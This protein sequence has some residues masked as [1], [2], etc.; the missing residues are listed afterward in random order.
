MAPPVVAVGADPNRRATALLMG[1]G[2]ADYL[3]LPEDV[4]LLHSS[5]AALLTRFQVGRTVR[6]GDGDIIPGAFEAIVARSPIMR[7]VLARA[8]RLLR[9]RDATALIIGETGTGKELLARAVHSG[10]PRREAPFV[11]VNCS[12]LPPQLVESE[13]FG[14]ERGAFTDAHAAN[15][16]LFEVAEGGTLFLDE[17]GALPVALQAKLL[18]VLENKEVRRVGGTRTRIADVRIIAATNTQLDRAV[19]DGT[20]RGDLFYRLS[21]LT[22][23]LP[24]LRERA[25][26]LEPLARHFLETFAREY[27]LPVPVLDAAAL[28]ALRT[29]D[30]P[31]NVRELKN[32]MERALLLAEPGH[33]A[34][35]ELPRTAAPR[36][37]AG[38]TLP[39][40]APLDAIEAAAARSMLAACEGNRSEAAR[41]LGISRRRLRRLLGLSDSEA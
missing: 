30:W 2:A 8:G 12:A 14:H 4:E 21:I 29:Y 23:S 19:E 22:V 31:G 41:R 34:I 28:N 40:P 25:E 7:G 35:D 16:G 37:P 27:G 5:L 20:F 11:P 17:I 24:P 18:R 15:P 39:F 10:G 32:A 6:H 38:S 9:H 1:A 3:V 33:V 26:D 36:P 13:L